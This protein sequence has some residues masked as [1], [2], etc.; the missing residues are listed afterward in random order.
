MAERKRPRDA[1]APAEPRATAEARAP[2]DARAGSPAGPRVADVL[3]LVFFGP[4]DTGNAAVQF[5]PEFTH[6]IFEEDQLKGASPNLR[7]E[8]MYNDV[9]LDTCLRAVGAP[10]VGAVEDS[11][12][13]LAAALP[14]AT[15]ENEFFQKLAQ[16]VPDPQKLVGPKRGE[17]S[18]NG[19]TYEIFCGP[20]QMSGEG[21]AFLDQLQT[22]MRFY[23]EGWS[24]VDRDDRWRLLAVFEHPRG[25]GRPRLISAT[26]IFHF[27]RFV[28][29]LEHHNS[30]RR[31]KISPPTLTPPIC[32]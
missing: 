3:R 14:R 15:D 23:I 27:K 5:P 8:C 13:A 7:I 6:Q 31:P 18:V 21:S 28:T 25:C 20:F 11:M 30:N 32:S 4:E 24:D 9:T 10:M 2:V 1:E 12:H 29:P 16:P 19:K 26:T 22:L 17:Y